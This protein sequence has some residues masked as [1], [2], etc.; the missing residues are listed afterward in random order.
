MDVLEAVENETLESH[1]RSPVFESLCAHNKR[2]FAARFCFSVGAPL[3]SAS[4][5]LPATKR[6]RVS[7]MRM[8]ALQSMEIESNRTG[9]DTHNRTYFSG[10]V[11]TKSAQER[12]SQL[13]FS[14]KGCR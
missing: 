7:L 14:I 6:L 12:L 5:L 10:W 11:R 1:S 9:R 2:A 13:Q 4:T 3:A 8:S